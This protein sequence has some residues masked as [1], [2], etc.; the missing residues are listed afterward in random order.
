M[1]LGVL[2]LEV[3]KCAAVERPDLCVLLCPL[4][5]PL[6]LLSAHDRHGAGRAP[7]QAF[8]PPAVLPS[9]FSLLSQEHCFQ[10]DVLL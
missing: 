7:E 8:L 10:G 3:G 5:C 9:S 1:V 4:L 6:S 2:G